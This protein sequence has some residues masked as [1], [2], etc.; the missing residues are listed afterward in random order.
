MK[1]NTPLTEAPVEE[2]IFD[3]AVPLV[4]TPDEEETLLD[5]EDVPLA[6]VPKTG[7]NLLLWFFAAVAS[8]I[9]ALGPG[10]QTRLK[11]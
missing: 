4:E 8:A 3:E 2:V 9:G 10:P 11:A 5:D 6:K 1:E 7:D